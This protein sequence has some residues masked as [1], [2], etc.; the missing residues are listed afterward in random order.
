MKVYDIYHISRPGRSGDG[1]A[2]IAKKGFDIKTVDDSRSFVSFEY[3]DMVVVIGDKYIRLVTVYW[4]PP[5]K[6]NTSTSMF[7]NE[8]SSVL[9]ELAGATSPLLIRGAFKVYMDDGLRANV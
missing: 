1:L 6:K 8:F 9:E 4:P 7:F 5:L 3:L 2:I